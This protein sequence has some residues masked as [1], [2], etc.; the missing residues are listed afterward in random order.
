M[1]SFVAMTAKSGDDSTKGLST[2]FGETLPAFGFWTLEAVQVD[3][4]RLRAKR[5]G[6]LP[7]SMGHP[8]PSNTSIRTSTSALK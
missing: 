6:T 5:G 8:Q 4:D 1:L 7:Q 2:P 3:S